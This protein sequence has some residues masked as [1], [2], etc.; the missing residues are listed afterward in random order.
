MKVNREEHKA[1]V[2]TRERVRAFKANEETMPVIV[3]KSTSVGNVLARKERTRI[4]SI[5]V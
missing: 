4:A 2:T 5:V 1:L 3:D